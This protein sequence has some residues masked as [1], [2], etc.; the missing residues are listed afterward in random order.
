[1]G[2]KNDFSDNLSFNNLYVMHYDNEPGYEYP[3]EMNKS[4]DF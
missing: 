3:K 4:I 2:K 1:M